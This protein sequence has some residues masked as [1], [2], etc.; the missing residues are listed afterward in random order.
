[1]ITKIKTLTSGNPSGQAEKRGKSILAG[2]P[3]V[4]KY[5]IYE[6][7]KRVLRQAGLKSCEY[8]TQLLALAD[9]LGI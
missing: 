4:D 9:S 6:N 8:E 5:Q 1:M 3:S 2:M 7:Q